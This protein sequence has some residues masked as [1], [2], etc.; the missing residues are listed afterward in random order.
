[1]LLQPRL[2]KEPG[3]APW[4]SL[5]WTGGAGWGEGAREG[6]GCPEPR[7][8]SGTFHHILLNEPPTA[9]V[10][11]PRSRPR[12]HSQFLNQ[13]H[14]PG[15]PLQLLPLP[16][17]PPP[18]PL[19][20]APARPR[21]PDLRATAAPARPHPSA[22]TG[23]VSAD[24]R[25]PS[26]QSR[27]PPRVRGALPAARPAGGS[28]ASTAAVRTPRSVARHLPKA[29]PPSQFIGASAPPTLSGECSSRF[30]GSR[31][32]VTRNSLLLRGRPPF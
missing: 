22:D 11:E 28:E 12:T 6:S 16:P 14:L 3:G 13:H 21:L 30:P 8:F 24:E 17:P 5:E 19:L 31:V 2:G 15:T 27:A 18:L 9:A 23:S 7:S 20:T 32:L 4:R 10:L 25:L 26:P 29:P 1:M